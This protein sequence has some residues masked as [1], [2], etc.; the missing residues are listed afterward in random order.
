[1]ILRKIYIAPKR[2]SNYYWE[3]KHSGWTQIS[4]VCFVC[5]PTMY[6]PIHNSGREGRVEKTRN[7]SLNGYDPVLKWG[8]VIENI[9]GNLAGVTF[10]IFY[11]G[12]T[13]IDYGPYV[14]VNSDLNV[15]ESLPDYETSTRSF[16][17]ALTRLMSRMSL[18]KYRIYIEKC[19]IVL[20]LT[21]RL[22]KQNT[23]DWSSDCNFTPQTMKSRFC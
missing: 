13:D 5:I 23:H 3:V 11:N 4:S 6:T 7:T 17:P 22:P 14:V 19:F 1:M 2:L 10:T 18:G 12:R 9:T 16:V 8:H 21:S 20:Y 15:L